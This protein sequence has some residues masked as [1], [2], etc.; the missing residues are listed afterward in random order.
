MSFKEINISNPGTSVKFGG[1]DL[2]LVNKLLN[3]VTTGIPAVIIKSVNDFGFADAVLWLYNQA[4]NRKTTL[5]GQANTPTTDVDL[6]LPPITGNDVLPAL[7]LAQS[8]LQKQQFNAGVIHQEMTEPASPAATQHITYVDATTKH[9]MRKNSAGQK[10]DYDAFVGG[11]APNSSTYVTMTTDVSLPNER[12]LAVGDGLTLTDGGAGNPVTIVSDAIDRGRKR[13]QFVDDFFGT[14]SGDVNFLKAVSGT[15]ADVTNLA[16]S[17]LGVYGVWQLTT[18]TTT[19]GKSA[20]IAG[21]ADSFS[22]GQG[23][24]TF[25]AYVKIPTLSTVGEEF[26]V[27]IGFMDSTTGGS[28]N[29]VYMIYDRLTSLNWKLNTTAV[30][31]STTTASTTAV[32][33][34][35][36]R[37]KIV[38]NAA[39]NSVSFF[40]NGTQ[41]SGSPIT[42]NIPVGAGKECNHC[43]FTYQISRNYSKAV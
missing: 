28:T 31:T 10:T 42:T 35:W 19:T 1:N 37:L 21:N 17:E 26:I 16:V 13:V 2:D 6:I 38:V 32:G 25:E 8:W 18:G 7:N 24:A 15:G 22:L 20:I 39:G 4:A 34:G 30:S 12:T 9:L 40:V 43:S 41:V 27:R 36:V 5:R 33:T 23:I 3:G 14:T 29:G 11:G